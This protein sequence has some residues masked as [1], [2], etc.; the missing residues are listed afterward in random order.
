MSEYEKFKAWLKTQSNKPPHMSPGQMQMIEA[1]LEGMSDENCLVSSLEF[2][3]ALNLINRF[4]LRPGR[5]V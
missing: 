1:H 4:R 2:E 5:R 3:E